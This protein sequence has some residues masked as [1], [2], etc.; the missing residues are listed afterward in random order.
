GATQMTK[1]VA[2]DKQE[3]MVIQG[4]SAVLTFYLN[5]ADSQGGTAY[6]D[7][8]QPPATSILTL[9]PA[10]R[11]LLEVHLD[12]M[13]CSAPGDSGSGPVRLAMNE[14]KHLSGSFDVVGT[15]TGGTNSCHITGTLAD[16]PVEQ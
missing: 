2:H 10:G 5:A 16:I 1:A 6:T 7:L 13:G 3:P 15:I 4:T 12:G 14:S 11:T 8:A 9:H